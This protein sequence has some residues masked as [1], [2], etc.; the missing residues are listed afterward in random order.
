VRSDWATLNLA[1]AE[2]DKVEESPLVAVEEALAELERRGATSTLIDVHGAW[3]AEKLA[4]A[5][6]VDGRTCAVLGTH[7]HVPTADAQV[8]P[9]GT[10]FIA[11]VGMTGAAD[12]LIGFEHAP[13]VEN[14]LNGGPEPNAASGTHGVLMGALVTA[15]GQTALAIE[16]VERR[17]P[18]GVAEAD[19]VW[20]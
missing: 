20:S 4:L 12:S 14:L 2:L 10:A 18:I 3:P 7:T 9:G 17:V 1:S 11:D 19:A 15:T 6:Q 13:F 16:R 5:H 8:L